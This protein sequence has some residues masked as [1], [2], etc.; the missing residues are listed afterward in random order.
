MFRNEVER[1]FGVMKNRFAVLRGDGIF[2]YDLDQIWDT[3]YACVAIHNF[4]RTHLD[5]SDINNDPDEIVDEV[6]LIV[7]A[8]KE[9]G[10]AGD[11]SD[12]EEADVDEEEDDIPIDA[13]T[14]RTA[15]AWRDGIANKIWS[16]YLSEN[17]L[18][19]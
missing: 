18:E 8:D 5:D 17:G 3:I 2:G 4:I 14:N 6:A 13:T 15:D 10:E 1:T 7:N 11:A 9:I 16:D 19:R 12:D